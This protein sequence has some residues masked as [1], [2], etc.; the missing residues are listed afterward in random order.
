MK[1]RRRVNSVV[2]RLHTYN[3]Q[4]VSQT[5]LQEQV[6]A[7]LRRGIIFSI[8]W[9]MGVGSLIAIVQAVKAR[10]I[11]RQSNGEIRGS[12][13][14]MWCF[15]VGGAGLLFW[16]FVILMVVIKSVTT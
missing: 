14:V 16:G 11:I 2:R 4:M 6:D 13:K 7:M 8:F 3:R 15:I 5:N 9:L 12:G 10:K 1:S